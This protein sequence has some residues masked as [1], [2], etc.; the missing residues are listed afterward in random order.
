MQQNCDTVDA[1]RHG[2][3][4]FASPSPYYLVWFAAAE[5]FSSSVRWRSVR[6]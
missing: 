3:Q 2:S 6:A 4:C 1:S 5:A